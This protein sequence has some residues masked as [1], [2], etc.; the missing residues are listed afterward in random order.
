[1]SKIM[2]TKIFPTNKKRQ[3]FTSAAKTPT[4]ILIMFDDVLISPINHSLSA[5]LCNYVVFAPGI[6]SNCINSVPLGNQYKI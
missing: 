4:R 6:Y 1:M 3:H 2:S 5:L